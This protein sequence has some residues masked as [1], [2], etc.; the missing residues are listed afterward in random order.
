M[1]NSKE[2]LF[3]NEDYVHLLGEKVTQQ[4]AEGVVQVFLGFKKMVAADKEEE[5]KEFLQSCLAEV[6]GKQ[7][8]FNHNIDM[9]ISAFNSASS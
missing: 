9:I 1:A 5:F 4:E 2:K 8:I 7:D 6:K 3:S